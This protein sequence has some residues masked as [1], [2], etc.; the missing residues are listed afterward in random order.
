MK[1][2]IFNDIYNQYEPDKEIVS[3]L[4]SRARTEK[5]K[6]VS[7]RPV[8]AVASAAAGLALCFAAWKLIPSGPDISV[9]NPAAVTTTTYKSNIITNTEPAYTFG[10]PPG[11]T[12]APCYGPSDENTTDD[13]CTHEVNPEITCACTQSYTTTVSLNTDENETK[14]PVT[15]VTTDE[16]TE[17]TTVTQAIVT[18][19]EIT[20]LPP[21][22]ESEESVTEEDA[23][24][25]TDDVTEMPLFDTFGEYCDYFNLWD[26]LN[27][28]RFTCQLVSDGYTTKI[29]TEID[30]SVLEEVLLAS[31]DFRRNMNAPYHY[32]NVQFH[33][34]EEFSVHIQKSGSIQL[35]VED[36]NNLVVFEGDAEIY[37]KLLRFAKS[38]DGGEITPHTTTSEYEYSEDEIPPEINIE[39]DEE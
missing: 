32:K 9:E 23:E 18:T 17:N 11:A 13:T 24:V 8:I 30:G 12:T 20:T 21:V 29:Y 15:T 35:Y 7:F 27:N 37:K 14:P 34:N 38:L 16:A 25:E 19:T 3:R 22:S 6:A 28:V 5:P 1:E 36:F 26:K 4:M 2:T 31:K 10:T 33:I 39:P